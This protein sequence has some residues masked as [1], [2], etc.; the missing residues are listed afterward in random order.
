MLAKSHLWTSPLCIVSGN[1]TLFLKAG[2]ARPSC[3]SLEK[4]SCLFQFLRR[5]CKF[6]PAIRSWGDVTRIMD[7]HD[8][9]CGRSRI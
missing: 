4:K 6:L 7:K 5:S 1:N 3:V 2:L 9:M 8:W